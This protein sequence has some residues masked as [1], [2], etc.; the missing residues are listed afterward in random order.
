M[1]KSGVCP[2]FFT[3]LRLCLGVYKGMEQNDQKGIEM[4]ENE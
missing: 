4:N 1:T 2:L 3:I